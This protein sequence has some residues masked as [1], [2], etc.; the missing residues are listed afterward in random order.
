MCFF[1]L[2]FS[3]EWDGILINQ[4]LLLTPGAPGI[5]FPLDMAMNLATSLCEPSMKPSAP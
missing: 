4:T 1:M 3:W 2:F 5:D